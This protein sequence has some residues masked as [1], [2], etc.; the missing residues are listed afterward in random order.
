MQF[1]LSKKLLH[2]GKLYNKLIVKELPEIQS[3]YDI[4]IL[5][6]LFS[7]RDK[8]TQQDIAQILNVDKSHIAALIYSLVQREYLCLERNPLDRREHHVSLSEKG[9]LLIP[10][11]Q[12][13]IDKVNDQLNLKL[14]RSS[15]LSFY[16]VLMQM[17]TNL[18]S[19]L[20][21]DSAFP[22]LIS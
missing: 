9:R 3:D 1:L 12:Q 10:Q 15:L 11:I 13:A 7:N 4:V 21:Q 20:S 5:S 14:D 8:V 18:S 22:Q 19:K 16:A 2:I 17:E 6:V